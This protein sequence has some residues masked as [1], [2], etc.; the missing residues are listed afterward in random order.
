ALATH[1]EGVSDSA[2]VAKQ[3]PYTDDINLPGYGDSLVPDAAAREQ[4]VQTM[5]IAP[6]AP[7]PSPDA[8]A[9]AAIAPSTLRVDVENGSGVPGAG[10]RIA[11][12][13]KKNGFT[14]GDVTN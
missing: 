3:V 4:L 7:L 6:P 2:I 9:L 10:R 13:L 11:D 8:M 14:I 1:Y 5:L 12:L